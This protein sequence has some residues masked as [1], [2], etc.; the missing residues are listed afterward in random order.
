VP[1]AEQDIECLVVAFVLQDFAQHRMAEPDAAAAGAGVDAVL[2]GLPGVQ[3]VVAAGT[4]HGGVLVFVV[5]GG[6]GEQVFATGGAVAGAV[7]DRVEAGRAA[8]EGEVDA[9]EFAAV[10]VR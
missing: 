4:G 3:C 5:R 6:G 7:E 10:V 1:L 2:S 9:A 8:L